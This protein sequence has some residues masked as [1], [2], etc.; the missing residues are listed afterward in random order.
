M[1][2]SVQTPQKNLP[3]AFLQ[4]PAI[5]RFQSNS[6][7]QQSLFKRTSTSS[8]ITAN[9]HSGKASSALQ[10]PTLTA[11]A[12]SSTQTLKPIE[13]A[14]R[15]INEALQLEARFPDLDSYVGRK[16]RYILIE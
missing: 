11:P 5:S 16:Y 1:S 14:A 2:F 13:R 7:P 15:T 3:G 4:T 6:V 12:A 10:G 9:D 8:S